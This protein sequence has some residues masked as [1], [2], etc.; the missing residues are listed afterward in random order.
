MVI[1]GSNEVQTQ[2]GLPGNALEM[3]L[4]FPSSCAQVLKTSMKELGL[5]LHKDELS[6]V[7]QGLFG[8]KAKPHLGLSWGSGCHGPFTELVCP[9]QMLSIPVA[10]ADSPIPHAQELSLK[11]Q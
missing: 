10:L 3:A 7:T 9:W 5:P 1:S 11:A 8:N 2:V 4:S 6:H